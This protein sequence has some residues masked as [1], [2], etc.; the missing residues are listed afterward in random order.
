VIL[1]L[2]ASP[3]LDLTYRVEGLRVGGT[4]RVLEVI[5]RPGG[6]AINVARLLHA[7]GA[8]VHVV[9][10]AGGDSGLGLV[11]GLAERGIAHTVV[12]TNVPTRRT[13]AV[14][15]ETT[16][17]VTN[18]SEPAVM[19]DWPEFVAAA[20]EQLLR[21]DVVVVSGSFPIGAPVDGFAQLT[22]M[23]R[24]HGR[25]V[26]VDT[27]G[28]ALLAALAA[29]PT[30][31]KPNAVE[32]RDLGDES[33]PLAAT[34]AVAD[35][36]AVGVVASLGADGVIAA[37]AHGQW[38]ATPAGVVRGNPTG[39]GDAVVAG[40]AR[41]L[42]HGTPWPDLL[43]DC[44]ALGSAAVHASCAGELDVEDYQRELAGVAVTP[45]DRVS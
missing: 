16:H 4:N 20:G 27:S 37:T 32:L 43:A 10:T 23:A 13:T 40:L 1:C 39:A 24:A 11:A 14:V 17:A 8:D 2:A 33:D 34:R 19:R 30:I 22:T 9:T 41:G 6:K 15:D 36:W 26:I 38:Q 44:V 35:R 3:A 28:P 29:G 42:L 5:E 45:V 25:P 21:A 12:P 7:L 31:V 18:L